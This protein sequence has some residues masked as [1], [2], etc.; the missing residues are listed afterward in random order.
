MSTLC[1]RVSSTLV[2]RSLV[3]PEELYC[4]AVAEAGGSGATEASTISNSLGLTKAACDPPPRRRCSA[5]AKS[6]RCGLA[7][8]T[9]VGS[10]PHQRPDHL[11]VA[12]RSFH[13]DGSAATV[14]GSVGVGATL[15]K[16][17]H[18]VRVA[19]LGSDPDGSA[20]SVAG[21]VRVGAAPAEPALCPRG[22]SRQ[23]ARRECSRLHREC[24]RRRRTP[25]QRPHCLRVAVIG[26]DP[27]GSEAALV[28]SLSV[29]AP[30]HQRPHYVCVAVIGSDPDGSAVFLP[31][32]R[33]KLSAGHCVCLLLSS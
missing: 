1:G 9:P 6:S 5:M 4:A 24:W 27:D 10:A 19:L 8:L 2:W 17:P 28:G 3:P 7:R 30:L 23:R 11:G 31:P 29:C 18:C 14:V 21:S 12:L 20:A 16:R 32:L 33:A 26:S 25:A 22:H 15:H 13:R